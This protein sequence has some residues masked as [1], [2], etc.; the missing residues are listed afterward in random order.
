M[1]TAKPL[2]T[3]NEPELTGSEVAQC[4]RADPATIRNYRKEGMPGRRAGYRK[5]LYKL[6]EVNAWLEKREAQKESLRQQRRTEAAKAGRKT[7][8]AKAEAIV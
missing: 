4:L 1:K 7:R 3:I 5:F 8:P 6:S 2:V